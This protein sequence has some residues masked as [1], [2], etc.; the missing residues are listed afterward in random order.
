MSIQS[1]K[2]TDSISFQKKIKVC[3]RTLKEVRLLAPSFFAY[4]GI[5]TAFSCDRGIYWNLYFYNGSEWPGAERTDKGI[6]GQNNMF[7]G[8]S[9]PY[10]SGESLYRET[11]QYSKGNGLRPGEGEKGG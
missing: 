2:L 9:L 7:S 11:E 8:T 6:V 5:E 1:E 3:R 10:E 4:D